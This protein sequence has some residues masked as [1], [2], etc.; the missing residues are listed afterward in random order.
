MHVLDRRVRRVL[1]ITTFTGLRRGGQCSK[2]PSK[3]LIS[4]CPLTLDFMRSR[5]WTRDECHRS[6]V[7]KETRYSTWD[8]CICFL[9]W[10]HGI[11]HSVPQFARRSRVRIYH[12]STAHNPA[13]IV[14]S[15]KWTTRII[16][17]ILILAMGVT[18]L[19]CI[20]RHKTCE[21]A[22]MS[23]RLYDADYPRPPFP[24]ACLI[25]SISDL[26]STL[27]TRHSASSLFLACSQ[28]RCT[29]FGKSRYTHLTYGRLCSAHFH[30]RKRALTRRSGKPLLLPRLYNQRRECSRPPSRWCPR[31]S[32]RYVLF[33]CSIALI[34]I[35]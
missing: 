10:R 17:S 9:D 24:V 13:N 1:A 28:V 11:P 8:Q 3:F 25:P 34:S 31:R 7:Q 16:A 12:R 5:I 35:L 27:H 21:C 32:L 2:R 19:V 4:N 14:Y 30:R 18:N 22:S 33:P 29:L 6:L 26:L 15:F 23:R 20:L